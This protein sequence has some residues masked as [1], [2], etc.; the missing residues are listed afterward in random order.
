MEA[1]AS[2]SRVFIER[3]FNSTACKRSNGYRGGGGGHGGFKLSY[4]PKEPD[5]PVM[6]PHRLPFHGAVV[7]SNRSYID[8]EG[9]GRQ[10][11]LQHLLQEAQ[12]FRGWNRLDQFLPISMVT[13]RSFTTPT[14]TGQ[15]PGVVEIVTL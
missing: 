8:F 9:G 12:H 6:L 3:N 2:R 4:P 15:V 13:G 10:P 5:D 14:S 7:G 1:S 11:S